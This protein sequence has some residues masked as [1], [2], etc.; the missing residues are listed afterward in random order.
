L[1]I[2]EDMKTTLTI[3]TTNRSQLETMLLFLKE[4]GISVH[5]DKE[6]ANDTNLSSVNELSLAEAWNSPE[7][8]IW[9]VIY[10]PK[11]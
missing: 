3:E 10:A 11:Q 8:D 2:F 7:D 5:I 9:D 4:V 6:E 1:F